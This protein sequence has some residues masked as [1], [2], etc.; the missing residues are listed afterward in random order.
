MKKTKSRT[1]KT[2]ANNSWMKTA[3]GWLRLPALWFALVIAGL[4]L[5]GY[6]LLLENLDANNSTNVNQDRIILPLVAT[7][8]LVAGS[9]AAVSH[10]ANTSS[11]RAIK[12]LSKPLKLLAILTVIPLSMGI[13]AINDNTVGKK[14]DVP[15]L[16]SWLQQ[17]TK[18]TDV[19]D[20]AGRTW[21]DGGQFQ[22]NTSVGQAG[23]DSVPIPYKTVYKYVADLD[24]GQTKESGGYGG[25]TYTCA[26]GVPTTIQPVDKI[27]FVGTGMT[28]EE[29]QQQEEE[30]QQIQETELEY[31]TNV[32]TNV[33]QKCM[34]GTPTDGST[35]IG[36]ASWQAYCQVQADYQAGP[37]P[38]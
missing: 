27:V 18:T 33:F 11:R 36:Y 35:P 29:R 28:E 21:Q 37:K 34:L 12:W 24:P 9:L 30:A 2:G 31:W 1:K 26:D 17:I 4:L 20:E 10:L 13:T 8:A 22:L 6:L 15:A 5:L 14:T 32:Y 16:P 19:S 38:Q 25:F 3:S 23:C 7:A